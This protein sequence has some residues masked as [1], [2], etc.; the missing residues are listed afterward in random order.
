MSGEGVL[1][2]DVFISDSMSS[3]E[4]HVF[5]VVIQCQYSAKSEYEDFLTKR[6]ALLVNNSWNDDDSSRK[7]FDALSKGKSNEVVM[8][9]L[10]MRHRMGAVVKFGDIIQLLHVKSKKYLY[11]PGKDLARD[12]RENMLLTLSAEGGVNSWLQLL[13]RLKIN[14]E[15]DSVSNSTEV[16]LRIS[17]RGQEHVHC[18]ERAPSSAHRM[19][20]VNV[21]METQSS[22]R[23]SIYQSCLL[24][25][26]DAADE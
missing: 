7:H 14:K 16:V 9:E 15:G 5:Q 21:S 19:R 2:N 10:L 25:T 3:F 20:E 18:S 23:L 11:V 4:D 13:P 24:Y 8:N 1:N 6:D 12:E 26:S 17:E 22:F